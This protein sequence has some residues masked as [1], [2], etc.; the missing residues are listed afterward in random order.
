[1]DR[2]NPFRLY[3]LLFLLV[4]L[5]VSLHARARAYGNCEQGNHTIAVIGYTSSVTTPVQRSY[6][7]CTVTIYLPGTLTLAV[8]YSDDSG[9][10]LGNPFLSNSTGYW[11]FY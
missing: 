5:P 3:A 11:F 2:L 4:F 9:T 10:P 8:I 7:T 6:P 1:M